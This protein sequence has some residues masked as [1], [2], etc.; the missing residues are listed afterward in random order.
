MRLFFRMG[1]EMVIVKV[2]GKEISF[3][4]HLTGFQK[5]VSIEPFI[6]KTQGKEKLEEFNEYLKKNVSEKDMKDYVIK[7]FGKQGFIFEGVKDE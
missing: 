4:N 2:E 6:K 3:A 5:F 1:S 7:E